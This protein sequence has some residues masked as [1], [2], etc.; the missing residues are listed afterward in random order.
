MSRFNP[1]LEEFLASE[2]KL[3]RDRIA[4][5]VIQLSIELKLFE[6]KEIGN[7]LFIKVLIRHQTAGPH[8]II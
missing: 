7:L 8:Y 2:S 5:F 6:L 1:I 4:E 3:L